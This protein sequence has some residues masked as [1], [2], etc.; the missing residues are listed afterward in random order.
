MK[1]YLTANVYD[2]AIYHAEFGAAVDTIKVLQ[3]GVDGSSRP[4]VVLNRKFKSANSDTVYA[5]YIPRSNSGVSIGDA[6]QIT[7]NLP[8][9]FMRYGFNGRIVSVG[10]SVVLR[11]GE[12]A[13]LYRASCL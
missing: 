13:V 9:T 3:T 12:G 1:K 6:T 7:V 2:E 11:Q 8:S 5:V 4:Y 10:N